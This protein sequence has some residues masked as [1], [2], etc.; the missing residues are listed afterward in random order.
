MKSDL[1]DMAGSTGWL[2]KAPP[3]LLQSHS[4]SGELHCTALVEKSRASGEALVKHSDPGQSRVVEF[5]QSLAIRRALLRRRPGG[6]PTFDPVAE[7]HQKHHQP[8]PQFRRIGIQQHDQKN[9]FRNQPGKFLAQER[10][11]CHERSEHQSGVPGC[12]RNGRSQRRSMRKVRKP[13]VMERS[14]GRT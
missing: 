14:P 10:T 4:P 3:R 5:R 9:N 13:P 7:D 1:I 11:Q 8:E 12:R 2:G 6:P